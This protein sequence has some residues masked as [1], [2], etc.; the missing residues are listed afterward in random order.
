MVRTANPLEAEIAL[1]KSPTF[2]LSFLNVAEF[3]AETVPVL[4]VTV[5]SEVWPSAELAKT[6]SAPIQSPQSNNQWFPIPNVATVDLASKEY[7][8]DAIVVVQPDPDD[9]VDVDTVDVDSIVQFLM[10]YPNEAL[11]ELPKKYLAF[12][13]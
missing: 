5:A 3:A 10:W 9:Q 1:K 6:Q 13:P 2:S 4:E 12:K 11:K 7:V 8:S